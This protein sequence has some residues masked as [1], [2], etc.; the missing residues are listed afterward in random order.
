MLRAPLALEYAQEQRKGSRRPSYLLPHGRR[1]NHLTLAARLENKG[2]WCRLSWEL[3]CS[4]TGVHGLRQGACPLCVITQVLYKKPC[5]V[6][7]TLTIDGR[8]CLSL[9][10]FMSPGCTFLF[11]VFIQREVLLPQDSMLFATFHHFKTHY[12]LK[13][14]WTLQSR[15][16]SSFNF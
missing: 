7:M 16:K 3:C 5:R 13:A 10:S 15:A 14:S 8:H 11:K 1:N 6:A 12:V 9:H 2:S 4:S